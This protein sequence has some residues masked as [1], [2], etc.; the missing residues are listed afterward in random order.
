MSE[1]RRFNDSERVA[2]Y[3][4]ADGRC[5]E[6]GAELEPGWHSD[7]ERPWSKGGLTDVV[8]GQA[9]CPSCNLKK[10]N[11][12]RPTLRDWQ[13]AA[14][15]AYRAAADRSD[16]LVEATP[17]SGKTMLALTIARELLD[18]GEI[19][20]VIVVCPTA[21]LKRQWADAANHF[22]I[23]LDPAFVNAHG[24]LS[25]DYDGA[26]VTYQQLVS[27]VLIVRRLCAKPTL[28]ILD[29]VHHCGEEDHSTWGRAIGDAFSSVARRR[30]LLSGTPFREDGRPIPFVVYD[31]NGQAVADHVYSYA[32]ALRDEVCRPVEF[33]A[34]DGE[35]HWREVTGARLSTL[36][37]ET[38]TE[39]DARTAF[40]S[41]LLPDGQWMPDVLAAADAELTRIREQIPDAGGLVLA[42][43]RGYAY[44]Y[45]KLLEQITGQSAT[46]VV[47]RDNGEDEG[48]TNP[49]QE[50]ARF[51]TD[52]SK[53]WL[54]AVRM[55]SEGVDVPRLAVGVY[56]TSTWTEM[57]FRQAVG[58]FVRRRSELECGASLFVPSVQQILAMAARIAD[59]V[60]VTLRAEA[61]RDPSERQGGEQITLELRQPLTSGEA[62]LTEA[63]AGGLTFATEDL[64]QAHAL[65]LGEP[66]LANLSDIQIALIAHKLGVGR[67]VGKV[68]VPAPEPVPVERQ[69]H[70]LKDQVKRKVN[71]V[72]RNSDAQHGHIHAELNRMFGDTVPTAS[73]ETLSKRLEVLDKWLG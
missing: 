60:D 62:Q 22:G 55:V 26:A 5:S 52:P 3:I 67:L 44:A 15:R 46:I 49:S 28:V 45:G 36:L 64:A 69:L 48:N 18:A 6:C 30:L 20:R 50:I 40:Q 12:M 51:A 1:R 4:A 37:S 63:I 31:G 7:H 58:R 32:D 24:S 8:N 13:H 2:L 23:A 41:A 10:G 72:A 27:G 25:P 59:Q 29:E 43:S 65:K 71:R 14:L 16:F 19:Q 57:F 47:S 21:H 66:S 54:V 61:E 35:M 11:R 56:A 70:A 38:A 68:E 53:R 33:L 34:Y 42:S 73:I 39:R 9:L 17:G